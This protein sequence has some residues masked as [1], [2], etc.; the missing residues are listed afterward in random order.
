MKCTRWFNKHIVILFAMSLVINGVFLWINYQNKDYCYGILMP[1]G[2]V[3]YNFYKY[4]SIKINPERME[5]IKKL[6]E[7]SDVLINYSDISPEKFGGPTAYRSVYD[8]VGYGV[9]LGLIW[10]I[11][12][13]LRYVDVQILQIIIFSFLMILIYQ[14]ALMLFGSATVA[15]IC[16]I[17]LL[18]F[19]PIIF[20]NVQA[21]RDI[22]A[23]YGIVI[24]LYA[25]LAYKQ[26][27]SLITLIIGFSLF[28]IMQFI[29][30]II[31]LVPLFLCGVLGWHYIYRR[32]TLK[33]FLII[34]L[35]FVLTNGF[36]FWLPF[37]AY[38]KKAHNRYFVGS[39]ILL[40]EGL[41]EEE[42]KWGYK[43]DD[44]WYEFFMRDTYGLK[45][46]TPQ[47]EDKA[48]EIFWIAFKEDPV[49]FFK[50]FLKRCVSAILPNLPWSF[51]PE[52]LYENCSTFLDKI[53]IS[54]FSTKVF[55]DFWSR[56]LYVRLF[57]IGGYIGALL[58]LLR[59][60]YFDFLLLLGIVISSGVIFP[61]HIEYRYLVPFYAVP[62]PL[63]LGYLIMQLKK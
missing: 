39:A 4:N 56:L 44:A 62:F 46:G 3:G 36:F 63:F 48:K 21:N 27:K 19:F 53:K 38:T 33:P 18:C 59:R 35:L 55:L 22:W 45:A 17:A 1:H 12:K 52:S 15:F 37:C 32:K 29:R 49:F 61:S 51:Y 5:L 41:G 43:L 16:S 31:V 13:S 26:K 24:L 10:K 2:E 50:L 40:I 60:R 11:T 9:V 47:S 20:Q 14:I 34:L 7:K 57:L 42:N 6:Q 54:F 58:L 25:F 30:P 23:Y 8:T 28:S